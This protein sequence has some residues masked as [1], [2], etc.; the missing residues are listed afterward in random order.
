MHRA[1]RN[2]DPLEENVRIPT[3]R[4][5]DE[6]PARVVAFLRA[7]G[8]HAGIRGAMSRGGFTERDHDE[9]WTLLHA[10]CAWGT[11][12]ID[13]QRALP[14]RSANAALAR[15]VVAN[16]ARFR[17][18]LE[19]VHPAHANLFPAVEASS[20]S[21]A[22]AVLAVATLLQRLDNMD[23]AVS[24]GTSAVFVTLARRGLD[25]RERAHLADLV[26]T[27]QSVPM[28][29]ATA[30][31]THVTTDA[32]A[33]NRVPRQKE[34]FCLTRWFTDRTANANAITYLSAN[35]S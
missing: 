12:G 5:L 15:W 25:A 6:L 31:A 13:P 9:G 1:D 26:Y 22:S 23:R 18:A 19:R 17:A 32:D 28:P 35:I 3:R 10:V 4:V 14:A 7:T 34:L 24:A 29:A 21:G 16:F 30:P 33:N 27:A 2:D 8:T 11:G 20:S